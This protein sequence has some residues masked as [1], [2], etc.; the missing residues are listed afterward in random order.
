MSTTIRVH[1]SVRPFMQLH[2]QRTSLILSMTNSYSISH[3]VCSNGWKNKRCNPHFIIAD[4]DV[5][6]QYLAILL[7]TNI[8]FPSP[9]TAPHDCLVIH[10]LTRTKTTKIRIVTEPSH[11]CTQLTHETKLR[12]FCNVTFQEVLTC[13]QHRTIYSYLTVTTGGFTIVTGLQA[14]QCRIWIPASARDFSLHQNI[15]TVSGT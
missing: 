15:H 10:M 3:L 8:I 4:C 7:I 9:S 6:I 11:I 1:Q 5:K 2:E 13:H 14:A 12:T